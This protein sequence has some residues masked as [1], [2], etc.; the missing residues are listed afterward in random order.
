MPRFPVAGSIPAILAVADLSVIMA[1]TV[2][3][4]NALL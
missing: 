3:L 4:P 1:V 2:L